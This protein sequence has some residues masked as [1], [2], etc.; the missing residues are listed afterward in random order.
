[1]RDGFHDIA[2]GWMLLDS[3]DAL[4]ERIERLADWTKANGPLEPDE[5]ATVSVMIEA[6]IARNFPGGIP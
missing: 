6:Q 2:S 1:M 5:E 3:V 4:T